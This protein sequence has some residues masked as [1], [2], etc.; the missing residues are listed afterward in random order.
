MH[1]YGFLGYYTENRAYFFNIYEVGKRTLERRSVLGASSLS[2]NTP[3][4]AGGNGSCGK[5]DRVARADHQ[6]PSELPAVQEED[7]GKI[8]KVVNGKW[9]ASSNRALVAT[10]DGT[11]NIILSTNGDLVAADDGFGNIVI[12]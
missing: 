10:D 5:S 7:N 11:G 4:K 8:M 12:S 9:V 6:H 2:S 3:V 1:G